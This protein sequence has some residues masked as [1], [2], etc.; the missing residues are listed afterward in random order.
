M[1][2][3]IKLNECELHRLISESV[4]KALNEGAGAAY[5]V[6]FKGLEYANVQIN[7]VSYDDEYVNGNFKAYIK[8]GYVEWSAIGYYCG[9]SSDGIYVGDSLY[10]DMDDEEKHVDGGWVEGGF[11]FYV[12]NT[13]D[14]TEMDEDEIAEMLLSELNSIDTVKCTHGA[15]YSHSD[16]SNP[17]YLSDEEIASNS[18]GS[19]IITDVSIEAPAITNI[20]NWYFAHWYELGDDEGDY[21]DDVLDESVNGKKIVKIGQEQ[22]K[23]MIY[24]CV[25]AMRKR[26]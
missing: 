23:R 26:K 11:S 4:K 19:V 15:G 24:E 18:D 6:T 14:E 21:S 3:T 17:I 22:F 10:Q 2:K 9:L 5:D 12:R 1:K 8:P 7:Q 20:I 16:L 25:E 13:G